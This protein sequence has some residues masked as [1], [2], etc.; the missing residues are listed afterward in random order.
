M[1][2]N[3]RSVGGLHSCGRHDS[4]AARENEVRRGTTRTRQIYNV[5]RYVSSLEEWASLDPAV[6]WDSGMRVSGA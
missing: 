4:S 1:D 5:R 6:L 3:V 2:A